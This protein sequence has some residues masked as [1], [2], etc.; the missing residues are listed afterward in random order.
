MVNGN[1]AS[2]L[3]LVDTGAPVITLLRANVCFYT[4]SQIVETL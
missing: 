3:S 4:T 2:I 1:V